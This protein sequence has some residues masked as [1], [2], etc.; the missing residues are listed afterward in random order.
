MLC[1]S[2]KG[3]QQEKEQKSGGKKHKHHDKQAAGQHKLQ[4]AK[5][6]KNDNKSNLRSVS[7]GGNSLQCYEECCMQRE[8]V[9]CGA[10]TPGCNN[11]GQC[12]LT[13]SQ[14]TSGTNRSSN[15]KDDD[16]DDDCRIESVVRAF[17]MSRIVSGSSVHFDEESTGK[18]SEETSD[19][20][21]DD[22]TTDSNAYR[23]QVRP[24]TISSHDEDC[25]RRKDKGERTFSEDKAL[26]VLERST[27]AKK[28]VTKGDSMWS[29][30]HEDRCS[31]YN[32]SDEGDA[33]LKQ[34]A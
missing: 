24:K 5:N 3:Q 17:R 34:Q 23:H 22:T 31:D 20:T 7:S 19:M 30:D 26:I 15:A 2:I 28:Q 32:N 8:A 9:V 25:R 18:L 13:K 11:E 10:E 21:G 29:R 1:I 16:D 4:V 33:Q 12:R 6:Q 27:T 14:H